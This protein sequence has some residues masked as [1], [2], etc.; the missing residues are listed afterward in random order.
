M[1]NVK[2]RTS[3]VIELSFFVSDKK[4]LSKG[5]T[6]CLCTSLEENLFSCKISSPELLRLLSYAASSEEE[7]DEELGKL[8]LP[9]FHT[10]CDIFFNF[11]SLP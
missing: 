2:S 10:M 9:V 11:F 6:I 5:L 4:P 3:P 8:S 7:E 1:Q